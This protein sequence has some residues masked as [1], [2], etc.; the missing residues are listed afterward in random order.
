MIDKTWTTSK[1]VKLKLSEMGEQHLLNALNYCKRK[2]KEGVLIQLHSDESITFSDSSYLSHTHFNND[3]KNIEEELERR[4]I[5]C[6]G[7]APDDG[8]FCPVCRE[9]II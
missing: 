4:D 2:N 7:V 9:H 1:G 8:G 5:Y 6:C 3:I